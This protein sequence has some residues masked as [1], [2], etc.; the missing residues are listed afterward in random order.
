[1]KILFIGGTGRISMA[2]TRLAVQQGD[3]VVLLNRGNRSQELPEGVRAITADMAD[4]ESVRR[5][6]ADEYFDSV[7]QFIVFDPAQIERDIRLFSGKTRQYIFISSASA[8]QKPLA[9]YLVDE[10]TPLF[11]PF[12]EYSQKKIACEERLLRAYREEGFPITIVRP[13]HTYDEREI[14]MAVHGKCGSWQILQRMLDGKPVLLHGDGQSLW[15]FTFNED[16]AKGFYGLIGNPHA[17]GEAVGITSDESLTWD[18]SYRIV[19]Q[20]LGVQPIICHIATDRLIQYNPSLRGPLLGDKANSV[21][22]DNRKL[23]RLVPGFNACIRFDQG[24]ER[25]LRYIEAHP[26]YKRPDPEFDRWCDQVI[27]DYS[28]S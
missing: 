26:E 17:I 13:S 19:A 22:F 24:V 11:N 16:F 23:K 28:R 2:C 5:L 10:S 3:E 1:M 4:E 15:T 27:S 8:Y 12:W 25:A 20:K 14:P 6:L 7:A 18:A 9:H 21:V